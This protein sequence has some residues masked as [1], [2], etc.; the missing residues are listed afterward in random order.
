M[1]TKIIPILLQ[2]LFP[3][4]DGNSTRISL[5]A[6]TL[7]NALLRTVENT[8]KETAA[9]QAQAFYWLPHLERCAPALQERARIRRDFHQHLSPQEVRTIMER[10]LKDM[11]LI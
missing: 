2:N 4:K 7:V 3:S 8:D 10:R 11:E 1:K 9:L 6:E 5:N